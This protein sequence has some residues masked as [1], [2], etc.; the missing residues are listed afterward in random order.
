[1]DAGA[2]RADGVDAITRVAPAVDAVP[3]MTGGRAEYRGVVRLVEQHRRVPRV[4]VVMA[5]SI[6]RSFLRH[7]IQRALALAAKASRQSASDGMR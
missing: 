4:E 5:D 1:M 7:E 2:V 3:A 6:L